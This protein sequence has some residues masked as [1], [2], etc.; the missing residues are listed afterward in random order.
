VPGLSGIRRE[1]D[2]VVVG[3]ATVDAEMED[4]PDVV[5]GAPL[6]AKVTPLIGHFQIRNRGTVGGS[7]AHADPSAEYPAVALTLDAEMDAVS[8]RGSR[9]IPASEF[10]LGF[11][12]TALEPDELLAGVRF[13]VWGA[14][15]GFGAREFARR[16]G[17]FAIAGALVGVQLDD[18]DRV[19]RCSIGLFGMGTTPLRAPVAEAEVLGQS[20]D[21][22]AVELGRLAVAA[23]EDVPSDLHGSSAYRMRVGAAMVERAWTDAIKEARGG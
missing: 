13:P 22:A 14:R 2:A 5:T 8:V 18:A 4:H 19:T 9:R 11:W 21:L 12:T 15:S 6:V 23:L 10:F 17:D 1:G 7:I 16:H 3:A 20:A